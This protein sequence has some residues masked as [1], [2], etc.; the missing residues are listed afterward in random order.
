MFNASNI[1][2]CKDTKVGLFMV[3][4]PFLVKMTLAECG[5][6]V[7]FLVDVYVSYRI[8]FSMGLVRADGEVNK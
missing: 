2:A 4:F 6:V 1:L 3:F 8:V 5:A 7:L